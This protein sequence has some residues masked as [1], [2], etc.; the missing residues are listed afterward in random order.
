MKKLDEYYRGFGD[1]MRIAYAEAMQKGVASLGDYMRARGYYG[2]T[3]PMTTEVLDDAARQIKAMIT[4]TICIAA[5]S[6]LID[7]FGFGT[8]RLQRWQDGFDKL[9]GYL[10]KGWVAWSDLIEGI[11]S[12]TGIEFSV[13]DSEFNTVYTRPKAGDV[14]ADVPLIPDDLWK[15]ML[16]LTGMRDENGTVYED[17]HEVMRYADEFEK[18]ECYD[19]LRG[20]AYKMGRVPNGER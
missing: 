6:V 4:D 3:V 12:R 18:I 14:Y 13:R 1:G 5:V 16:E 2:L 15:E 7:E 8:K 11:R 19:F 20:C 9:V 17:D 10:N